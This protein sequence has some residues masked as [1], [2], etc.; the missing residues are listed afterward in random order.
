MIDL[1]KISK[2][3][4]EKAYLTKCEESIKLQVEIDR[5]KSVINKVIN[6]LDEFIDYDLD[7]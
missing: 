7:K 4:L 1:T 6:E 3:D 5:L 2:E